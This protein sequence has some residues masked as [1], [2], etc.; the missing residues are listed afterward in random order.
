LKKKH[1]K[2]HYPDQP[3]DH[4]YISVKN[5]KNFKLEGYKL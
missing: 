1:E 5:M 2:I 4:A 3:L